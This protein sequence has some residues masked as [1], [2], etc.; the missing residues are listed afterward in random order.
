MKDEKSPHRPVWAKTLSSQNPERHGRGRGHVQG[1]HPVAHG[2]LH[3]VVAVRDGLRRQTVPL[4]AEDNGELFLLRQCLV[5]DGH[6]IVRQSHGGGLE[7]QCC[8]LLH[9]VFA[10]IGPGNLEH[11]AHAHSRGPAVQR[12]GAGG[13]QQYRV[14]VQRRR[15]AENGADVGG[16]H[17]VLQHRDPA[18][19]LH[20]LGDGGQLPAAH[21]AQRPPGQLIA[22]ELRQHVKFRG[23][24]RDVP[25]PGDDVGGLAMK[26]LPLHQEG[27]RLVPGVQGPVDD[28]GALG[29]EQAVLQAVTVE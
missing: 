14:H 1:I 15:A 9:P 16:V 20:R 22:G 11:R 26:V 24:H 7:A 29:D 3:G 13:G 5:V 23:V 21:G 19:V 6:G 28:L 4:G 8:Q 12:V 25:A 27:H 2:D 18:G 10:E 17:H